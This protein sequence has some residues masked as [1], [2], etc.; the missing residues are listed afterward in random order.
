[1]GS[2]LDGF[3][4]PEEI[5]ERAVELGHE[6]ISITDHGSLATS[7]QFFKAA[8]KHG[9]KPII[10]L[11]GYLSLDHN[12][13]EKDDKIFHM[14]LLATNYVGY[15][16][17]CR[18]SN[19][20]WNE[21]FYKKPRFD[22]EQL[23]KHSEGI[24]A[25]SG[26]MDGIVSWHLRNGL[27]K[28]AL[29]YHHWFQDIF[30]DRYF[31]EIQPWNPEGLNKELIEL[32]EVTGVKIVATADAHYCKQENIL[33]E[34]VSLLINQTTEMKVREKK[35][36]YEQFIE[37][38]E[39]FNTPMA[40]I[41]FLYPDRKLRF[42][43][44][45]N[46]VMSKKNLELRM[47]EAGYDMPDAYSNTI[48]VG[49]MV[50]EYDIPTKQNY[51]PKFLKGIDSDFYLRDLAQDK[52]KERGLDTDSRYS[53]RL[54]EELDVITGL[55]FSDY[56]LMIW[57]ACNWAHN[58]GIRLGPGRG[59]VGG[60]LLAYVLGIT[61]I[62]PIK[63]NL[64][65]W[66]FLSMDESGKTTRVDPPD[67]DTD[68]EDVRRDEMKEYMKER[69]KHTASISAVTKFSSKGMVRD[70][71]R[72]FAIPLPE[73]NAVCKHFND[74]EEFLTS[75]KTQSFRTKYPEIADLA[76][77]FEGRWRFLGV[78][79]AGVVVADRPLDS[80]LPLESR[81]AGVRGAERIPVTGFD[82]DDV[83]DLGLIKMDFLGLSMLTIVED[84]I[85]KIKERHGISLDLDSLPLDDE[86]VL[87]EFSLGHTV[88]VF[89]VDTQSYTK[90]LKELKVDKFEDLMASNALVRPGPLLTVTP[91]YIKRKHGIEQIPKEHI[92]MTAITSETYGLIIYQ[93]Q[94]MQALVDIGG[95]TQ[96]EAD[97]VR[98]IIG[99]K[100]DENEFKPFEN[101]WIENASR[102][103][104]VTRAKKLWKDF[105]KFAGYAFNKAHACEYSV[106]S[107]QTM[108][109]KKYYTAEFLYALLKNEKDKDRITTFM[110]EAKRLGIKIAMPDVNESDVTFSIGEDGQTI[111]FGLMNV[112]AVGEKAANEIVSKRPFES[113]EDFSERINKRS[114][115]ATAMQNLVSVGAF[116]K[117]YDTKL[118]YSANYYDLLGLAQDISERQSPIDTVLLDERDEKELTPV[119]VL[120]KNVVR[121]PD[122]TR[123]EVEDSSRAD[124]YFTRSGYEIEEGKIVIG[125]VHGSDWVGH[126]ALDDFT[127]TMGTGAEKT[128]FEKFL[129]GETFGPEVILYNHGVG[130]WDDDKCLVLPVHVRIFEIKNG[131]MKGRRMAHMVA[132]DGKEVKKVVIFP[133]SLANCVAW[134]A[135]FEP[136]VLK[137]QL[138]KS[139]DLTVEEDGVRLAKK[140]MEEKGL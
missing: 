95:F 40:R 102:E 38:R 115:N 45:N 131:K 83:N 22:F 99:K 21:G 69:W 120:V 122:W 94:L 124:S 74:L 110:F 25:L 15:Q 17:L 29:E 7:L 77:Q 14:G 117:I 129:V 46:Y 138:T 44:I 113:L 63:H 65:F 133:R 53:E 89:Q 48:L 2:L 136:I 121:K 90:L 39:R 137:K 116:S 12:R 132:T 86:A 49:E 57:D 68:I 31:V 62:D 27:T 52:L 67:I 58:N 6:A 1:M 41:N 60:S 5:V 13:K 42:D 75:E 85:Q 103:L 84:C 33:A 87:N 123:I 128:R 20:A 64:L 3:P 82:M 24:I 56:M 109:L 32:A 10:G 73:V 9:I 118:D 127:H 70:I 55:H 134:L 80:L 35:E 51:L 8:K 88:G 34:E 61:R 18:L 28:E 112:S 92:S 126:V 108:W 59:S 23:K 16:N 140:L 37:S 4:T 114:C 19:L 66:R 47:L 130:G 54:S 11:E 30:N 50:E 43:G 119:M 79:A 36:V 93:E 106:L 96:A 125:L 76:R 111:R 105:L 101:K 104:G 100:R 81:A 91:Q 78:H 71:S 135:P 107:Y 139:G 72:V 97:K 98:K 26:C